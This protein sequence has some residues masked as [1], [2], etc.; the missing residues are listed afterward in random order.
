MLR[1]EHGEAGSF[2]TGSTRHS[3]QSLPA[4]AGHSSLSVNVFRAHP[5]CDRSAVTRYF[6]ALPI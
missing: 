1:Q 3:S 5:R 4:V 2:L 6:H